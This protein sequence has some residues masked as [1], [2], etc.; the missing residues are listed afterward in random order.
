MFD[1]FEPEYMQQT[2]SEC[3]NNAPRFSPVTHIY[4]FTFTTDIKLVTYVF[5]RTPLLIPNYIF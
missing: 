3:A 5:C 4:P 1:F 2:K